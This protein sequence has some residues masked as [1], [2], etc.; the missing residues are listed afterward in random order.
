VVVDMFVNSVDMLQGD[1]KGRSAQKRIRRIFSRLDRDGDGRITANELVEASSLLQDQKPRAEIGG[2]GGGGGGGGRGRIS[3]APRLEMYNVTSADVMRFMRAA[4]KDGDGTISYSEFEHLI[5]DSTMPR[6]LGVLPKMGTERAVAEGRGFITVAWKIMCDMLNLGIAVNV[7][8]C[9]ALLDATVVV[10]GLG[11][12]GKGE[13]TFDVCFEDA[14]K[15]FWMMDKYAIVCSQNIIVV[16]L[17]LLLLSSYQNVQNVGCA[18]W[19]VLIRTD[20]CEGRACVL[21]LI[22]DASVLVLITDV[23]PSLCLRMMMQMCN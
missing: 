3:S 10:A 19:D 13:E 7:N 12:M 17:S 15:I 22:T 2:G 20:G 5:V 14:S 4:D 9:N 21:V 11:P 16:L 18:Y 1:S 8:A 23:D 6:G